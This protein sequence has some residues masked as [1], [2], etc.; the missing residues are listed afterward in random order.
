[1]DLRPT[2]GG[3]RAHLLDQTRDAGQPDHRGQEYQC[4]SRQ[5]QPSEHNHTCFGAAVWVS[6]P[7]IGKPCGL[8]IE[9]HGVR[10][11]TY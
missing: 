10:W 8:P 1:M 3:G 5:W 7:A 4:P 9:P 2:V 6:H 11:E